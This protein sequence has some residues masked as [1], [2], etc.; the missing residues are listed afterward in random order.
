MLY[1]LLISASAAFSIAALL[2]YSYKIARSP[3]HV[4]GVVRKL[5]DSPRPIDGPMA[6]EGVAAGPATG[7]ARRAFDEAQADAKELALATDIS[8]R[9]ARPRPHI[10]HREHMAREAREWHA[11]LDLVAFLED[12]ERPITFVDVTREGRSSP[13]ADLLDAVDAETK[14][15]WRC[16]KCSLVQFLADDLR[17][18]RCR[19][20]YDSRVTEPTGTGR[21]EDADL[22]ALQREVAEQR[23]ALERLEGRIRRVEV[24]SIQGLQEITQDRR[25][26]RREGLVN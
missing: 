12:A 22:A 2:V 6:L 9:V 18:R 15:V 19:N 20:A 1:D 26:T 16:E 11:D 3:V 24:E 23:K 14:K 5:V 4:V 25:E 17:C 7:V 8:T 21:A 13:R 10:E